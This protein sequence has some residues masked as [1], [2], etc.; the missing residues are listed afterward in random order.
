M[1]EQLYCAKCKKT[2]ASTNFYT[3]KDG[4]KCEL[5]KTCLTL[6]IN[7]FE[8]DTFL[9]LLEKFDVPYIP[10]EWNV[11]RDRAYAKD[12][13]K[14]NGM[15]VFGKYLSKMKLK[16]WKDF[17]WADSERLQK[18]AEEKAKLYGAGR[19][20]SEEKIQAMKEQYE[21]GEITKE[22]YETYKEIN[23]PEPQFDVY[24]EKGGGTSI[25]P[26]NEAPYE[27]VELADV[28][29][30]LTTED[31]IYL[32]TKWGQLYTAADWVYLEKKYND[33]LES[34]DIQGAARIDTLIQICKVSLKA[35]QALD[36][37]DMDSYSKLV[38]AYDS[39]M[40]SAKF[41]EAQKKEDK[42]QEFSGYGQIVAFCEKESGWIPRLETK[43]IRDI[44]DKDL[45]DM[46]K[47]TKE[48]VE[49]DPA[50]YKQ[51]ENYIKKRDI[52]TEQEE[53]L[54]NAINDGEEGYVLTDNDLLNYNLSIEEQQELD[55]LINQLEE[56]ED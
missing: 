17:T 26:V 25:Y 22:Q 5:C 29:A 1:P 49:S 37:G 14:M 47:W 10:Q 38:R 24:Q 51:I 28:G 56:E 19:E 54:Q 42:S 36:T 16:Q 23:Q 12:P 8:P 52:N 4:S 40:K 35:N 3:Y 44:A 18:E 21:R 53:D 50:I 45:D 46:K 30:D 9:W 48:L 15:S 41:T 7:N 32:A 27:K 6:R 33:F 55:N 34:F 2:M 31:K 13:Y 43:T 20:I 39:L 11:L